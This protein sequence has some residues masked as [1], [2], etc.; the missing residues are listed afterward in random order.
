MGV[1]V[2]IPEPVSE[3]NSSTKLTQNSDSIDPATQLQQDKV[4][5]AADAVVVVTADSNSKEGVETK[6][7]VEAATT[8]MLC[9]ID[10]LIMFNRI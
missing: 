9:L 6:N 8:G 3:E 5:S 2:P 1:N 4:T 7:T 10:L